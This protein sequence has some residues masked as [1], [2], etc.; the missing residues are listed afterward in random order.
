M[1]LSKNKKKNPWLIVGVLVFSAFIA[2][3][4]ETILNVAL[5][6]ISKDL[7]VSVS[8]VQWLITG[9]MLVTSVMVPI[10]AFL[11]ESIPTK[12]LFQIAMGIVLVGTLGCFFAGSFP[13]L[14]GFRMFQAIGT[15]MMIPI[16]MSTT[17]IVAPREKLGAAMAMCVMGIT[18]GPAFGPTLSGIMMQLF[19]WRATFALIAAFSAVM[20]IAGSL[21]IDNV[22][23][24]RYP[25]LDILSVVLSVA[26]LAVFLYGISIVA[27]QP[28]NGLAFIAAGAVVIAF[29]V[30]RQ[31]RL[32]EPMLSFAPFKNRIFVL[33]L[34]MVT[35]AMLIN[36]SM[37][38]L[39]PSF[40]QEAYGVS[41]SISA[42][43]LLPG[44][45]LNAV[46]TGISGKI[47]DK[48]GAG[49]MIPLGFLTATVFLAVLAA[50]SA[51]SALPVVIL[52]HILLYQG[53]AFSMSPA[54]TSA[55][56]V[57]PKELNPHGVSLVNTFM[58]IAASLGSS[59][60]GGIS[61]TVQ[62][63][64]AA[65]GASSASAAT[66]GF[67]AA[68]FVAA[69]IACTG[70]ILALIFSRSCAQGAAAPSDAT[71]QEN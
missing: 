58:Q 61:A 38:V 6:T 19:S 45:L 36:F 10:T 14:L 66:S 55:L 32:A 17:L 59:L 54:Q 43:V 1:N 63:S 49:R 22:A 12:R 51:H 42:I 15:G 33:G 71:A 29:F 26:G 13:V 8:A 62:A 28:L 70:L 57:L 9:Y 68:I 31:G 5:I 37:N 11:Y 40:L 41:S 64:A 53:L 23:E 21:V 18:L 44:I 46:S 30:R 4:N 27:S 56:A 48:G 3:F 20:F 25:K 34:I 2:L 47:L 65:G 35:I 50:F 67:T 69:G 16:M 60:F 52:T 24:L 39:M 7:R